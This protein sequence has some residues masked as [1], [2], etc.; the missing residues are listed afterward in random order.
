MVNKQ[1]RLIIMDRVIIVSIL[2]I[3]FFAWMD[4]VQIQPF[5]VIDTPEMWDMYEQTTG[6]AVY[7]SWLVMLALIAFVWYLIF[8]DKSEAVALYAVPAI[9]LSGGWEDIVFYFI[10]GIPF[11]GAS[12]P[13]LNDNFVMGGVARL[14]GSTDVT[15][16]TLLV[17]GALTAIVAYYVYKWLK[18]AKW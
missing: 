11:F 8:K 10:G 17:S 6:M 3:V 9:L 5:H 15:S 13:W 14:M 18:K 2:L 12:M 1:Q 4:L 7:V 16:T